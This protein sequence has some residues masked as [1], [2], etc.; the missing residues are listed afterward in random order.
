MKL[1]DRGLADSLR[2]GCPGPLRGSLAVNCVA[3]AMLHYTVGFLCFAPDVFKQLVFSCPLY[4]CVD[5]TS[6]EKQ[7]NK[8]GIKLS[9]DV[10]SLD[11][12]KFVLKT[13]VILR[14]PP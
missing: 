9:H 5:C 12:A 2:I 10:S 3:I 4:V 13:C 7:K 11:T 1:A 14:T 8:N 6:T